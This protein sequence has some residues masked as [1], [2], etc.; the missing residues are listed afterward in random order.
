[1]AL[2]EVWKFSEALVVLNPNLVIII[3]GDSF[4]LDGLI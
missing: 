3:L 4:V 1:M 2:A